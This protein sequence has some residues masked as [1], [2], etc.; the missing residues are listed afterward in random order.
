MTFFVIDDADDLC[1]SVL[2]CACL[3]FGGQ[4]CSHC[5]YKSLEIMLVNHQGGKILSEQKIGIEELGS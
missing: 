1:T 3:P 4:M 2:M 5:R